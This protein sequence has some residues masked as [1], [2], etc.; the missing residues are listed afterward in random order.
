MHQRYAHHCS[1]G[2]GDA[3]S[4]GQEHVRRTHICTDPIGEG[5][6]AHQWTVPVF[7]I[8]TVQQFLVPTGQ[9]ADQGILV[10]QGQQPVAKA[11]GIAAAD[12]AGHDEIE[13]L[14][15]RDVQGSPCLGFR[16]GTAEPCRHRHT[17]DDQLLRRDPCTHT[18]LPHRLVGQEPR[19][20][21]RLGQEGN[22]G[23]VRED[24]VASGAQII[25]AADIGEG[26]H[27]EQVGAYHRIIVDLVD[28]V[29]KLVAVGRV[30]QVY[31]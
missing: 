23:I 5:Y 2:A 6:G 27:G 26:L 11:D 13:F 20:Q 28:E 3:P 4:L 1:L 30:H 10:R 14:L 22:A 25:V 18:F 17:G 8:Q 29:A 9:N 19:V 7:F 24:A 12:A 16:H 21:F 31:R 15:R